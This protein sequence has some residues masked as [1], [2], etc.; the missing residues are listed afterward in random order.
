MRPFSRIAVVVLLAACS[1]YEWVPDYLGPECATPHGVPPAY[2][3]PPIKVQAATPASPGAIA[4]SVTQAETGLPLGG[5]RIALSTV[6]A[7]GAITDSVGRFEIRDVPPGRYAIAIRRLGFTTTRDSIV[8]PAEG[9]LRLAAEL[10]MAALD[11]P[12]SGFGLV[13]VRK[14]WWKLW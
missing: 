5:A 3:G 12:C 7:I 14:P 1:R 8:I 6:P 10:Q 2:A 13:R 9:G 11:G 4:G